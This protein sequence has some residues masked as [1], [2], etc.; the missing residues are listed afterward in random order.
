ME[1]LSAS[2]VAVCATNQFFRF[3]GRSGV[4]KLPQGMARAA[5]NGIAVR[6]CFAV[7]QIGRVDDYL[8]DI[9]RDTGLSVSRSDIEQAG[10]AIAK[11]SYEIALR[12]GYEAII[13]PAG[14]RES[15]I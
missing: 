8:R 12:E 9:V 11:R 15:I 5:K 14:L 10:I 6:P 13:M 1:E 4:R 2:G 3:A 7:Q